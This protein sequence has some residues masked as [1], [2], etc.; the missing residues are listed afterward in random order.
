[1]LAMVNIHKCFKKYNKNRKLNYNEINN[2]VP[3]GKVIIKGFKS[4]VFGLTNKNVQ[5]LKGYY[6]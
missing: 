1:M 5:F 2:Q 6:L 4:K 3:K